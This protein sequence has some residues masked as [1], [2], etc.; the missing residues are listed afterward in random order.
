MRQSVT[1]KRKRTVYEFRPFVYAYNLELTLK[2][3]PTLFGNAPTY[4]SFSSSAISILR[5]A[6]CLTIDVGTPLF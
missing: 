2:S 4:E 5:N 3:A 6:V 1:F